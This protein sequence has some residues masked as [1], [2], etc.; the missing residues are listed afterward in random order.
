MKLYTARWRTGGDA[1]ATRRT[2]VAAVAAVR[3]YERARGA[4]K[5]PIYIADERGVIVWENEGRGRPLETQNEHLRDEA[6]QAAA[7]LRYRQSLLG[8]EAWQ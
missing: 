7:D 5:L 3:K 1:V 6:E 4:G 2:L 8:D